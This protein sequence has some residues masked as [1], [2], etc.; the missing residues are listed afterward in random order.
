MAVKK[1]DF[2]RLDFTGRVKETGEVFD[3]TIEDV[4]KESGLKIKKTFGPVPVIV[5]GGHLIKGLD[6]AVLGMEE[7]E[8]KHVELEP[9]DAFGKRDPKLI[10]LIPMIEFKRQGIKPRVGM[11]ITMEGHEGRIQS[12][13]G[14]RV[15]VDFNHEL[16]GKTLEYDLKVKEIIKDDKE[17]V[18]SMIQLY[19]PLDKINLDKIQ[20][21]IEDGAAKIY[22]D[23][24]SRFDNRPYM[25]VTLS[26]FRIAR[27]IWENMDI[28]KVEFVDVFTKKEEEKED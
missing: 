5:G 9:E 26:K 18:K 12:I 6:E 24:L 14:G 1:G 11:S 7:G 8:E 19:Y 21:E 15:R 17:K 2:I 13:D 22:M 20:V 4:A 16:A 10:Q 3:T 27:D 23:E 25:D 28:K